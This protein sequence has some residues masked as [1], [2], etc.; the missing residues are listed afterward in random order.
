MPNYRFMYDTGIN[1][2][3]PLSSDSE[4]A[5]LAACNPRIMFYYEETDDA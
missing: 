2:L 5:D 4:A 1:M 3:M